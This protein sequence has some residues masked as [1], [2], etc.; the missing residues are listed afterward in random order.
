MTRTTTH[1]LLLAAGAGRR[2]G[3]PKALAHDADG[4]SWLLRSLRALEPCD[5]VTVVIGAAADQVAE[6]VPPSVRVVVAQDWADGLGRSLRRGLV[7]LEDDPATAVLISLVDLPDVDA[8][9]VRRVLESDTD[10]SSLV[11]ATYAGVPGHPVLIGR[12][13]WPGV[14]ERIDGDGGARAYLAAA[15]AAVRLVEC[16]DLATGRDQDEPT[17]DPREPT[18]GQR[19]PT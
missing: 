8:R 1:G 19:P 3:G 15:G 4:T 17:P 14:L 2:F 9:V 11:R 6:L 7:S 12:Q 5:A 16:G 10:A 18:R 13:H